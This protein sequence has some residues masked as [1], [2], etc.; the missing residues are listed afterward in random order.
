MN[1][2]TINLLKEKL[3]KCSKVDITKISAS[4]VDN[5]EDLKI[6]KKKYGADR[7]IE[8]I[9]NNK[10]PYVFS[11]DGRIVKI[12]FSNNGISAEECLTGVIRNIYR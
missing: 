5:I 4:D 12:E 3:D 1:A 2:K 6:S 7:I 8:F 10:N 11:V 9:K